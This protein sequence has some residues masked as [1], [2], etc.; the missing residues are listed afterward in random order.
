MERVFSLIGM[1]NS[2]LKQQ[3]I[4]PQGTHMGYGCY[5]LDYSAPGF[6]FQITNADSMANIA[7]RIQAVARVLCDLNVAHNIFMTK[8]II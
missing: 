8:A 6:G 4:P 3:F 7:Q 2:I 5:S 1:V